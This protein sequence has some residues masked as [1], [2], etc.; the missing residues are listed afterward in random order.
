QFHLWLIREV[1]WRDAYILLGIAISFV[2]LP[3]LIILFRNRP[4]DIGQRPDG[5]PVA[6][7]PA[8]DPEDAEE[9]ED[10]PAELSFTLGQAVRTRAY[11]IMMADTAFDSLG[12]TAIAFSAVTLFTS[13]GMSAAEAALIFTIFGAVLAVARLVAGIL[14]DRLPLNLMLAAA[15]TCMTLLMFSVWQAHTPWVV[16]MAGMFM[17]LQQGIKGAV[18]ST[19]WRRYYGR[20]HLGRIRGSFM[21]V[22]VASGAVGPIL[23]DGVY[24]LTGSYNKILA[25]L[26]FVPIPL[27]IAAFFATRPKGHPQGAGTA[28]A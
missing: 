17:G 10:D 26:A 1:G 20:A 8:N 13:R 15:A 25:P 23:F 16:A 7:A 21:T 24:D 19:L 4:E 14:A 28:P 2:L 6:Q 11:W 27:I 12:K 22:L 9:A 5:V 3:L 18:D